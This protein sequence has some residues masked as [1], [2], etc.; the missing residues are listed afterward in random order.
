[1][2]IS[3]REQGY[4][5]DFFIHHNLERYTGHSFRHNLPS[6][7]YVPVLL[8][9]LLPWAVYLPAVFSRY[10]PR[11]WR[12]RAERPELLMLWLTAIVTVVFFSFSG[13]KLPGYILPA[14]PPL[15]VLT[16]ALVAEWSASGQSDKQ[17]SNG[18]RSLMSAI[19]IILAV[20]TGAEIWMGCIDFWIVI[21]VGVSGLAVWQMAYSIRRDRRRGFVVWAF[22]G[23]IIILL[24]AFGH[25]AMTVYESMSGRALARLVTPDMVMEGKFC[26]LPNRVPS[27]TLY[28]GLTKTEKLGKVSSGGIKKLMEQMAGESRVYCFV[29]GKKSFEEL[30]KEAVCPMYVLGQN[31]NH[32]LV[33]NRPSAGNVLMSLP[34]QN[35]R[36][37]PTGLVGPDQTGR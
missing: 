7:I 27:F 3:L 8:V 12:N 6:I 31:A 36:T 5:Y 28:A 24:F 9:G 1:V 19:L 4:A 26:F 11:R 18:A 20:L 14:F 35:G 23:I 30:K 37:G 34:L 2:A 29:S 10:F 17:M 33:T 32:W 21:P 22:S 25:T 15:A 16:G 13:T